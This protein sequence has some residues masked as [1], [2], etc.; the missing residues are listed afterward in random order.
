MFVSSGN[1]GE[2]ETRLS[3]GQRCF[4]RTFGENRIP[5]NFKKATPSKIT[6]SSLQTLHT[7]FKITGV[8]GDKEM[9]SKRFLLILILT[10]PGN[11]V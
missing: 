2:E 6:V 9:H 7:T 8:K 3:M 10:L 11:Y 4:K 5:L 1:G